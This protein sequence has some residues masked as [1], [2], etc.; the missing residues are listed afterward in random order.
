MFPR[1]RHTPI[2]DTNRKRCSICNQPVYSLAGIHPQ[3][4]IKLPEG[5]QRYRDG[6]QATSGDRRP[7]PD[8]NILEPEDARRSRQ[9]TPAA[10]RP[11][12][13]VPSACRPRVSR[14]P[15][16]ARL[17]RPVPGLKRYRRVLSP[18]CRSRGLPPAVLLDLAAVR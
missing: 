9:V 6:D 5:S 2:F 11:V 4:A 3:C 13:A 17:D 14:P 18:W 10:S 7:C 15:R 1:Y 12:P 8:Q 16:P